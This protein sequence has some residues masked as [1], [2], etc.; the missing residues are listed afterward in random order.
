MVEKDTCDQGNERNVVLAGSNVTTDLIPSSAPPR[1]WNHAN[2]NCLSE[3]CLSAKLPFFSSAVW[4]SASALNCQAKLK[5]ISCDSETLSPRRATRSEGKAGSPSQ[6]NRGLK[7]LGIEVDETRP[8]EWK[9]F[10]GH[11]DSGES[12]PTPSAPSD[13]KSNDHQVPYRAIGWRCEYG[14]TT[15]FR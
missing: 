2:P 3:T 9:P 1:A 10:L 5:S 8:T 11:W 4:V 14:R 15:R 12:A 13:C 6:E 7:C